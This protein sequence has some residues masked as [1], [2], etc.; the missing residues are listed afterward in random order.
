MFCKMKGK[1]MRRLWHYQ[2]RPKLF[3]FNSWEK[4][5]WG[6]G[7]DEETGRQETQQT[8]TQTRQAYPESD[9]ARQNWGKTLT[10]WG[11]PGA[12]YGANL[13]DYN[14]IFEN[15]K[16]RIN[17]Y[18]WGGATGGGVIDKIKAGAAQRGVQDSPATGV[19]TSRMGAE[20]AG[21]IGDIS[22]GVD[23]EKAKAIESARNN[24][25]S[26]LTSLA[27]LSPQSTTGVSSGS[28]TTYA[29]ATTA[30][31]MFGSLAGAGTQLAASYFTGQ[32]IGSGLSSIFDLANPKKQS[33]PDYITNPFADM[34]LFN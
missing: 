8:Q 5:N 33:E 18:Y 6:D 1:D 3:G 15:A 2:N 13:P 29:P 14:A 9:V 10:D 25:L 20:E 30:M 34:K 7:E 24:W 11:Q 16:R 32:G 31:D 19:L 28:T 4:R 21:K 12:N 27:S 17:Q 26:S 22:V 23:T